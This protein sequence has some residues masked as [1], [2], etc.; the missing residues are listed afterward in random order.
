MYITKLPFPREYF[1]A[2]IVLE[3]VI[4][5]VSKWKRGENY[6]LKWNARSTKH[7][8]YTHLKVPIE[9]Y[10]EASASL[11]SRSTLCSTGVFPHSLQVT[12]QQ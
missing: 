5:K 10:L 11:K 9:H 12:F 3:S 8:N 7:F 2:F 6:L 4:I 1:L